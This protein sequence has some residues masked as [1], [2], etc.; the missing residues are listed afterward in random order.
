VWRV[1]CTGAFPE[2]GWKGLTN[3]NAQEALRSDAAAERGIA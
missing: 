2:W 3:V 1:P